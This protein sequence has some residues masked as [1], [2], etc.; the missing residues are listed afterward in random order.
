MN[1]KE[2]LEEILPF[3]VVALMIYYGC[4]LF[5]NDDTTAMIFMMMVIPV[6]V[7]LCGFFCGQ[8]RGF[9]PLFPVLAFLF[10]LPQKWILLGDWQAWCFYAAVYT[11]FASVGMVC[12]WAVAKL[13]KKMIER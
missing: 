9:R 8:R 1:P 13:V 3:A 11:L 5:M 6:G 7:F 2:R 4:P 12:G 10:F